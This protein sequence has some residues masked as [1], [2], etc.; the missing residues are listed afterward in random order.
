[1]KKTV[2]TGAAS[3]VDLTSYPDVGQKGQTLVMQNLGPGEIE[4]DTHADVT[5]GTGLKL[6]VGGDWELNLDGSPNPV[7]VVATQANTD[8]RYSVLG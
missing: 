1:M 2:G 4:F 8:L 3:K 5:I 7:Y 6:A